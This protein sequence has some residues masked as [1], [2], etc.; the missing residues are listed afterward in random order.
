[1]SFSIHPGPM[2]ETCPRL[3]ILG[4]ATLECAFLSL[5]HRASAVLFIEGGEGDG[6]ARDSPHEVCLQE[7][8]PRGTLFSHN[9]LPVPSAGPSAALF[10]SLGG[11]TQA[12]VPS[13]PESFMALS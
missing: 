10:V 8:L 12:F 7:H 9:S 5:R 13:G 3:I 6:Q 11:V 1:M 4:D 2:R